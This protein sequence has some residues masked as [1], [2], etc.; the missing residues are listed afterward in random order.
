MQQ[1]LNLIRQNKRTV[2]TPLSPSLPSFREGN[3]LE[4]HFFIIANIPNGICGQ[5]FI[6][7]E[8]IRQLKPTSP[9]FNPP[10]LSTLLF[11]PPFREEN[12]LKFHV[13][14]NIVAAILTVRHLLSKDMNRP[15]LCYCQ[16]YKTFSLV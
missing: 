10:P 11:L 9:F 1:N 8:Q 4:I 7:I 12:S 3:L 6:R 14:D 2:F 16:Y 13:F 5:I 15:K